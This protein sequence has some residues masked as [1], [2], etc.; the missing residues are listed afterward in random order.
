MAVKVF[1][2]LDGQIGIHRARAVSEQ[3]SEMHHLARLA[4]FDNQ[5]HLVTCLLANQMIVDGRKRQQTGNGCMV[6]V[7]AAIGKNQQRVAGLYRQRSRAAQRL[8]CLLELL[9][10]ALNPKEHGQSRGQKVAPAHS[11]Q[12]LQPPIGDDGMAELK[13]VA[14]LGRLVQDVSFRADIGIERHHQAFADRIDR[15]IGDLRESLFEVAEEQ[16]WLIRK[17]RQRRVDPH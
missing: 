5:R 11:T 15:R 10:T 16:L 9:F 17:A 8:D 6:F 2:R 14:V 1:Q 3:Q 7:H 4:G 12:F 13:R